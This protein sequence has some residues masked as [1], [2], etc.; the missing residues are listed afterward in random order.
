MT[1]E[2][3][4]LLFL[5]NEVKLLSPP[6][7]YKPAMPIR[8]NTAS[9]LLDRG[10]CS[11]WVAVAN[12]CDDSGSSDTPTSLSPLPTL[13]VGQNSTTT[14]AGTS[15]RGQ[16]SAKWIHFVYC[17]TPFS[18]GFVRAGSV[19]T[20]TTMGIGYFRPVGREYYCYC[21]RGNTSC[22]CIQR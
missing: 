9:R 22:D 2:L 5:Y 6:Y 19:S 7:Q 21:C 8:Y 20:T 15:R 3:I 18:N 11:F 1:S 13:E 14:A 16:E 10:D 12:S 17:L 4:G